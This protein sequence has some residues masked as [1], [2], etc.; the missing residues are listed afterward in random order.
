MRE[1][2][3]FIGYKANEILYYWRGTYW[4]WT[5]SPM[6]KGDPPHVFEELTEEHREGW[7]L[8]HKA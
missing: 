4:R 1:E 3:T 7:I 6:T 5:R 8:E 2:F